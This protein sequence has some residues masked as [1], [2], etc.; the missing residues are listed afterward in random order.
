[1]IQVIDKTYIHL[2]ERFVLWLSLKVL[3]VQFH[4]GFMDKQ[5]L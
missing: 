1:M 2:L 3:Q 4:N 5:N